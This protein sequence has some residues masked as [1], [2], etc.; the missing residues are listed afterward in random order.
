MEWFAWPLLALWDFFCPRRRRFGKKSLCYREKPKTKERRTLQ[1][2]PFY[3]HIPTK[4]IGTYQRY[5][6]RAFALS[7]S[8]EFANGDDRFN[9]LLDEAVQTHGLNA[10][11]LELMRIQYLLADQ[12]ERKEHQ[13]DWAVKVI[14]RQ[15]DDFF[16]SPWAILATV[17]AKAA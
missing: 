5:V 15:E 8:L 9:A 14:N 3:G 1:K 4:S 10:L 16:P 13:K 12:K 17:F 11:D 7:P 6:D 2:A